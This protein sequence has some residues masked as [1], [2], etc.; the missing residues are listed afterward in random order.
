[1]DNK[2]GTTSFLPIEPDCRGYTDLYECENCKRYIR[3]GEFARECDYEY[4]PYCGAAAPD[5]EQ[6]CKSCNF[7]DA[8]DNTCLR[9][10]KKGYENG[11]CLYP[12]CSEYVSG[13]WKAM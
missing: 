5:E 11:K 9:D 6:E 7:F 10:G 2:R 13:E 4:C 8:L 1:M 12:C 3:I